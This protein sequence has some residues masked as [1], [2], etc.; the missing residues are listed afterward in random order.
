MDFII[1]PKIYQDKLSIKKFKIPKDKINLIKI[2]TNG[3]EIDIIDSLMPVLKRDKPV[4]IIENNN[5]NKIFNKLKFLNYQKF[6]VEKNTLKKHTTQKNIN[7]I[8][9]YKK[10]SY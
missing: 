4:L 8:F 3:S 10:F 2:D 7:I 5:I 9:K 6:I 1:K